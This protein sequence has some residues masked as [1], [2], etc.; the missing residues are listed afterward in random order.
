MNLNYISYEQLTKDAFNLAKKIPRKYDII[1]GIPK[2]GMIPA[3]VIGFA[4]GLPVF[5]TD[6]I[7][8][9]Y[10]CMF[11]DKKILLIDDSI[12][13]GATLK[14]VLH[15]LSNYNVDTAVIYSDRPKPNVD[16]YQ[17]IV[18]AP[19]V[20]QWNIFKH[21]HLATACLDFDGVL[22]HDPISPEDLPDEYTEHIRNASP[23]HIPQKEVF[24]IISNRIEAHREECE[25]WLKKH[26]VRYKHLILYPGTTDQR[27]KHYSEL[28]GNGYWKAEQCKRIGGKWFMESD[29]VQSKQI[30]SVINKSVFCTDTMQML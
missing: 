30:K 15:E 23:L 24:A 8:S 27:R 28:G 29:I 3:Y 14:S 13:S 5:N 6:D 26:N 19:R 11:K 20:F 4:L 9:P 18:D 2:S 16:Y 12:T 25:T 17:K 7:E 1:V 22:C 10:F 21:G